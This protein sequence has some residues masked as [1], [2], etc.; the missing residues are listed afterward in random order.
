MKFREFLA[1]ESGVTELIGYAFA[2]AIIITTII[3][4]S[5]SVGP[6]V[7][8]VQSDEATTSMEQSLT[9]VD[10]EIQKVHQGADSRTF[11]AELPAGQ[12]QQSQETSVTVTHDGEEE[13]DLV[14]SRPLHYQTESGA[15]VAYEA[16]FISSKSDTSSPEATSIQR[17]SGTSYMDSDPVM[18]F[19][20]IDAMDGTSTYASTSSVTQEF[21]IEQQNPD[22]GTTSHVFDG[23]DD[24]EVVLDIET[25]IPYAWAAF[26]ENHNAVN[27]EDVTV[28]DDD[29]R[30]EATIELDDD[31][32]FTIVTHELYLTFD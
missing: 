10:E 31:E 18:E 30:V 11:D 12:L 20:E 25:E 13:D 8:S 1:D 3:L 29:D 2:F 14:T 28:E 32:K 23:A 16:G 19:P 6:I 15:E 26:L 5:V 27:S 9:Q 21:T 22:T 7:D 17:Q 24:N 4:V